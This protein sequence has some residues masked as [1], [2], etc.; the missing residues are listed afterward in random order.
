MAATATRPSARS[1]LRDRLGDTP[2]GAAALGVAL[3]VSSLYAA[4]AS[5]AIGLAEQSRWQLIVTV[6]AFA[7]LAGLLFGRGLRFTPSRGA[8]L[9]VG[10]LVAFA[11]WCA[12]SITWS[13]APDQ[14]WL[15]A[16]RALSYALVA[17]LAIALGSSL[18]RAAERVAL[19]YLAIATVVALY[20][21]G[22]KLFP[23]L[24][25]PGLIDLNHTERFSRLRAPLDYWNALALVCVMAVPVAVRAGA[26]LGGSARLRLA[27]TLSLVPLLTTVALTYSR[28]GLLCLA[29]AVTC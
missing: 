18:P 24:D 13:V 19:G 2:P 17:A 5:G 11:G 1:R 28:G 9:G 21:L 10:L 3:A 14:S 7:T 22:G 27:T 12:L 25:I 8:L 16:N 15:E 23:W 4:F 29:A 20:A 6:I 26:D